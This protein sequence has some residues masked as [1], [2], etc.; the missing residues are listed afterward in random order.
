MVSVVVPTSM[1]GLLI[2]K[3]GSSFQELSRLANVRL[4][5]QAHEDMPEKSRER[6]LIM[7]GFPENLTTVLSKIFHRIR[8]KSKIAR[9]D[10]CQLIKWVIKQSNCGTLIGRNGEGIK[11]INRLSGSWVKVAHLEEYISGEHER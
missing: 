9:E 3:N 4:Y 2:G 10:D 6:I 1:I 11:S 5:L 8:F 7:C